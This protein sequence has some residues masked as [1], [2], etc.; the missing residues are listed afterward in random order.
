MQVSVTIQTPTHPR[1]VRIPECIPLS[2]HTLEYVVL[3]YYDPYNMH[4]LL[5]CT[6]CMCVH[7]SVEMA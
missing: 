1:P 3:T 5:L 6:V 7:S 4:S 2:V